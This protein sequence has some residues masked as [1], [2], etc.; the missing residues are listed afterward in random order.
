MR[1]R[2]Y[3]DCAWSRDL[4]WST[5][6]TARYGKACAYLYTNGQYVTKQCHSITG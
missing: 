5:D 4:N 3:Y 6:W 1:G 2:T